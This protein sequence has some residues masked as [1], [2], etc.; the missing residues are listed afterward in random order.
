MVYAVLNSYTC[1]KFHKNS[2][3][4]SFLC[5][6]PLH[7]VGISYPP[8]PFKDK[9]GKMRQNMYRPTNAINQPI[10]GRVALAICF[11]RVALYHKVHIH[12]EYHSVCL[13]VRIGTPPLPLRQASVPPL[14]P[15]N[16]GY[17]HSP[18]CD[19]VGES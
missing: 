9:A 17:T 18:A 14:P 7:S 5:I 1:F 13:L 16:Q 2:R 19:G 6:C 8:I 12:L 15:P 3:V 10:R 11:Q 4:F